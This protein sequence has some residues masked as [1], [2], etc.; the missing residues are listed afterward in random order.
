M[1]LVF[2]ATGVIP[3]TLQVF[4]FRQSDCL[5]NHL[6]IVFKSWRSEKLESAF[7]A[8]SRSTLLVSAENPSMSHI[9]IF[10]NY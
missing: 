9:D 7:I 10:G 3:R 4:F 6:V 2:T 5:N 8:I 1:F